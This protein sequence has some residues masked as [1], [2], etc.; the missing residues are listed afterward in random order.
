MKVY[1]NSPKENWIVDRFIKEWKKYNKQLSTNFIKNSDIVWIISPWTYEKLP[2]K[3]LKTKKVLSTIHHID[4][5]KF[6][7]EEFKKLDKYV[8]YYHII[9]L[10]TEAQLKKLT[11]KK[12]FYAPFWI[13]SKKWFEIENKKNL[14]KKYSFNEKK[15]LIGSFQRDT[16]S[17]GNLEPKLEKGP[18]QFL[19]IIMKLNQKNEDLHVVLAGKKREFLVNKFKK[20]NISF[21]YYEMVS[22]K[23]LNELYN[24]LNLYIVSSRVEGGP[25]AILECALTKTP[26]IS[27]DV[28]IADEIL[29]TN[30]IYNMNNFLEASPNIEYAYDKV[31]KFLI[32]KG[33]DVFYKILNEV[34]EN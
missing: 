23:K 20:H 34:Y 28:G 10:K 32:P 11:N 9:S 14:R 26:I 2:K 16:E 17:K 18:D 3:V 13:D 15:Y 19:D 8:D 21:S 1:L 27:T 31:Q 12:I 4:E 33:F 22:Q 24:I 6:N 29:S 25:Q 7:I 5:N 30:S